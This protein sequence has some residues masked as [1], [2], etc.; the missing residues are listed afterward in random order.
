MLNYGEKKEIV[1][2]KY[3]ARVRRQETVLIIRRHFLKTSLIRAKSRSVKP[4]LYPKS[5]C[6]RGGGE[7]IGDVLANMFILIMLITI[8]YGGNPLVSIVLNTLL[9]QT[10]I[11]LST[12]LLLRT[13]FKSISHPVWEGL[14]SVSSLYQNIH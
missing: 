3:L 5:Y 10:W 4:P 8:F 11:N 2:G 14:S 9:C 1:S 12:F 6:T 7:C 13:V